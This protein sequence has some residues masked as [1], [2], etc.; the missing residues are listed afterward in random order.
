MPV[1]SAKVD[2]ALR[3]ILDLASRESVGP[4]QCREIAARQGIPEPF[5]DQLLSAL[6]RA[7]MVRSI[8][9][10][11]GGYVLSRSPHQITVGD[12]VRACSGQE[13]LT[14]PAPVEST[15]AVPPTTAWVVHEIRE[16]VQRAV[17]QILDETTIRDLLEKQ[18]RMEES[19]TAMFHI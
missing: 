8:R 19:Q 6:R 3:A 13:S 2:Y 18:R 11:A 14:L 1:F 17:S 5:L 7:G 16:R 10:P 9:G 15:T 12:V 4:V